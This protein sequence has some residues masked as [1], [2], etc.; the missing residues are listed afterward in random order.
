MKNKELAEKVKQQ[1]REVKDLIYGMKFDINKPEHKILWEDMVDNAFEL[2]KIVKPKHHKY[3]IKNRGVSEDDREFYNHFHSV[4]DLLKFIDNPRANDDPEDQTINHDFE[5]GIYSKR[6]G[7]IDKYKIKRTSK[8]WN[9]GNISIVGECDK[10]GQP[11]LFKNF[12]QDN[13]N[14][15]NALP[16]YLEYLW[17]Q[18]NELGLTHEKVQEAINELAK[19]INVCEKNTPKGVWSGY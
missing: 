15:P 12:R 17:E 10:K 5:M 14:Y 7:H 2:S 4:E 9:V 18:A 16:D 8:G 11:Y 3:M 19:W 13:I 1:W 6:W